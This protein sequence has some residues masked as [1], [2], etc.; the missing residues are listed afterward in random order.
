M[1]DL[2]G[3]LDDA[4]FGPVETYIQSGNVLFESATRRAALD[5]D[6]AAVL[7][8]HRG[9]PLTVVLRSH[10]QLANVVAKA[11][12]GFGQAP[13][14]YL[15]D[16]VFL[17]EPLTSAQALR[18][19]ERREG[20]D[21]VWPGTGVLY[22]ARLSERRSQSRFS[23]IARTPEYQRMTIR[24]WNTTTKLLGLLDGRSAR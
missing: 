10:R 20:V 17:K 23:R 21:Q 5:A 12:A 15:S 16:V 24:N 11:P 14:L 19:V 8:D 18:V 6:L 7:A 13:D 9:V 4:G 22:I 1:A 3:L 2:R